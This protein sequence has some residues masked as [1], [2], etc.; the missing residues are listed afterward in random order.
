MQF[1]FPTIA[2]ADRHVKSNRRKNWFRRRKEKG[3]Q[4]LRARYEIPRAACQ[5]VRRLSKLNGQLW[6]VEKSIG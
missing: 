6:K 1:K 3:K 2:H 4:R 5:Y